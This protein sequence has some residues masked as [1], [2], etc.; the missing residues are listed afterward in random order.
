[1]GSAT[2]YTRIHGRTHTEQSISTL[3]ADAALKSRIRMM[4]YA[5]YSFISRI[6]KDRMYLIMDIVGVP[7][8]PHTEQCD[9]G[10]A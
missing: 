10:I 5:K 4:F 1:M 9:K 3:M 6:T 8:N 7:V 2:A